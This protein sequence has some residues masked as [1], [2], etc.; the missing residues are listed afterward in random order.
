MI[1]GYIDDQQHMCDIMSIQLML[2]ASAG[3]PPPQE[4][5]VVSAGFLKSAFPKAVRL[6]NDA[7]IVLRRK[8]LLTISVM[9]PSSLQ[10]EPALALDAF[11]RVSSVL[12]LRCVLPH[13]FI[14]VGT[15]DKRFVVRPVD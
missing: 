5:N 12:V 8:A 6:L 1:S 13:P 10:F 15:L 3:N 14:C 9:L 7:D 4:E 11:V 2:F